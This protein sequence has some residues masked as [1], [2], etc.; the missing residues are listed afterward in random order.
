[1]GTVNYFEFDGIKSTDFDV[2]ISGE[3]VF[4]A[5]ERDVEVVT[6]PGRNGTLQIDNGRF[7][8][9]DVTYPA[10]NHKEPYTAFADDLMRLRNALASRRGYKRLTDTLHPDEFRL[11]VY[12]SGLE[13]KPYEYDNAA[14]FDITFDCKPQR[15]LTSGETAVDIS[16]AAAQT[17]TGNPIFINYATGTTVSTFDTE[18]TPYQPG[19]AGVLGA[20]SEIALLT[21]GATRYNAGGTVT[22]KTWTANAALYGVKVNHKAQTLSR[23]YDG[24]AFV[25]TETINAYTS[26]GKVLY[27]YCT[28]S[29]VSI[30]S[31]SGN[32]AF[33][34]RLKPVVY[35]SPTAL[36]NGEITH[37]GTNIYWRIDGAGTANDMKTLLSTWNANGEPL[38]YVAKRSSGTSVAGTVQ[39]ASFSANTAYSIDSAILKNT[40]YIQHGVITLAINGPVNLVNETDFEARPLLSVTGTGTVNVGDVTITI[41]GGGSQMYIDCDIAE[42]WSISG[43]NMVN[44]NGDVSMSSADFPSLPPGANVITFSAG[45]T[46]VLVTPRWWRV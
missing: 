38:V 40:E 39:A 31:P 27:Y 3:G 15:F 20:Y 22:T 13:V 23:T 33:C 4:N 6:I 45:I 1:M 43:G 36:N 35:T 32:E 18:I 9:I 37:N 2:I 10:Y 17:L 14:A 7:Q 11:G 25:G 19:G 34:S 26:G 28:M 42:A 5:P 44:R 16:S 12:K 21:Q 24:H 29:G 30:S 41:S 8:N 46:Q